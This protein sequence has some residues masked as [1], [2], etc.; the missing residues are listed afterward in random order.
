MQVAFSNT[1]ALSMQIYCRRFTVDQHVRTRARW[2]EDTVSI[3]MS[4]DRLINP[5]SV[6]SLQGI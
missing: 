4:R 2:A 6:K 5:P 3:D 1:M